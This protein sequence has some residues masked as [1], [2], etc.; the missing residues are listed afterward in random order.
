M[1]YRHIYHA[2]NFADVFKHIVIS[3]IVEYLKHKDQAF[4]VVDTHAGIGIYDLS[5]QQ[6]QKT[7]EWRDG[8]GRFLET[9]VP[10]DLQP[11]LAPWLNI[12]NEM[13]TRSHPLKRYPGSPM[14]IRQLLRRQDRLT[15]IELHEQ[16]YQQLAKNF[17]GD[18]QT[19]VLHLNG[20]LSLGAHLPPKEKRGLVVI[21]PPFE[22]AGEFQKMTDGL[23]KAYRRFPGGTYAFWYPVKHYTEL[24]N[25]LSALY[26][27]EIPK[28]LR[29]ELRIRR[30][31]DQPGLNGSGMIVVNPPYIL[32]KE[33]EALK[34]LLLQRLAQDKHAQLI[35]EW[36]RGEAV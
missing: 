35:Q 28:I 12:V 32:Q 19:R 3:R 9:P 34:P 36:V 31:S 4:R 13:N 17:A 29:L 14:I 22:E 15:A 7:G 30:S 2:G 10:T 5:S 11:L 23:I 25:Y 20:Y 27:T 26:D 33:I 1:N 6:A 18:Y 24:E 8:V 16:D 21:D